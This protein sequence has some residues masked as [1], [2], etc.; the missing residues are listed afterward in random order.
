MLVHVCPI[1]FRIFEAVRFAGRI[2]DR[3]IAAD[4]RPTAIGLVRMHSS[5]GRRMSSP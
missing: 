2:A 4:S 1:P 3:L 5:C